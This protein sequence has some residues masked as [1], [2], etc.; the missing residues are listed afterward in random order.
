M[1][2]P[3]PREGDIALLLVAVVAIGLVIL[4]AV[5][6]LGKGDARR[7]DTALSRLE[8]FAHRGAD[9]RVDE[10][11]DVTFDRLR[12]TANG[13]W[14]FV[15]G[16]D[17]LASFR[18]SKAVSYGEDVSPGRYRPVDRLIFSARRGGVQTVRIAP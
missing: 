16:D 15:R 1:G 4:G 17:V 8:S 7:G 10:L 11:V 5:H 9:R 14:Q 3:R 18:P 2:R 12:V 6:Y 13:H